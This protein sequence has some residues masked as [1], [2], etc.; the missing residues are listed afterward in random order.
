MGTRKHIDKYAAVQNNISSL[1][2][3]E[4][5]NY[6]T[7]CSIFNIPY[8]S[9]TQKENTLEIFK[10]FFS[11]EKDKTKYVIKEIYDNPMPQP[12]THKSDYTKHIEVSVLSML[13]AGDPLYITPT[14]LAIECGFMNNYYKSFSYNR[15]ALT[16]NL[17]K[18]TRV[19]YKMNSLEN[20]EHDIKTYV[21]VRKVVDAFF[22]QF[23]SYYSTYLKNSLI[24]MSNRH[25]ISFSEEY[26]IAF[27]EKWLNDNDEKYTK[28][29]SDED[30]KKIKA[31]EDMVFQQMVSEGVLKARTR[32]ALFKN[33][34]EWEKYYARLRSYYSEQYEW[35]KVQ[36]QYKIET[37][38]TITYSKEE[39][40]VAKEEI[41]NLSFEF[42]RQYKNNVLWNKYF[43]LMAQIMISGTIIPEQI[44]DTILNE[45]VIDN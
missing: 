20:I 16:N 45:K 31:A 8:Q 34:R 25:Q 24:S 18:I 12:L 5:Y 29:A 26:L 22:N 15:N 37:Q 19:I 42:A 13:T 3:G 32:N 44:F 27:D 39:R 6:K 38:N 4:K 21:Q 30:K 40:R 36:R 33:F 43:D 41:R 9:G 10:L 23:Y 28:I 35:Y 7:L 11:W 14:D 17:T 1:Q 2:V